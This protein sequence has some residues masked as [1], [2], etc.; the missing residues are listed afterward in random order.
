MKVSRIPNQPRK[1]YPWLAY[2]EYNENSLPP[3]PVLPIIENGKIKG[4]PR[5]YQ[6]HGRENFHTLEEVS[7]ITESTSA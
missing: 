2:V 6:D 7:V 3:L 4:R 5:L 1:I